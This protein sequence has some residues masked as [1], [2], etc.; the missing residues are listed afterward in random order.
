MSEAGIMR[1]RPFSAVTISI[2]LILALIAGCPAR[3]TPAEFEVVALEIDSDPIAA[4]EPFNVMANVTNKGGTDGVYTASLKVNGLE[5]DS[6][7]I[8]VPA[9]GASDILFP[10]TLEDTGTYTLE[11]G[12]ISTTL[13]VLKPARLIVTQVT[14]SPWFVFPGEEVTITATVRNMGGVTGSMT[15]ILYVNGV[16]EDSRQVTL[17]PDAVEDVSFSLARDVPGEYE[18]DISGSSTSAQSVGVYDAQDYYND[19]Y[20]F[21][22]KYPTDWKVE[23]YLGGVVMQKSDEAVL[24]VAVEVV[25]VEQNPEDLVKSH[26]GILVPQMAWMESDSN[27]EDGTEILKY[28]AIFCITDDSPVP[29]L[30]KD[31]VFIKNGPYFYTLVLEA[32]SSDYWGGNRGLYEECLRSFKPPKTAVDSYTDTAN[33]FSVDLPRGWCAVKPY[34]NYDDRFILDIHSPVDGPNIFMYML[35]DS[36]YED[37]SN[38][39]H[40]ASVVADFSNLPDYKLISEGAVALGTGTEGYEYVFTNTEGRYEVKRRV[41]SIVR[42][43]QALTLV[44]E[45]ADSDYR[46]EESEINQIYDSL[47]FVEKATEH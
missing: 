20:Y 10:V 13:N 45:A 6:K 43:T 42:G 34:E 27:E 40:A 23:E 25:D 1:K 28:R 8:K 47:T 41:V 44:T 21:S 9:G 35:Q 16:E 36:L 19:R 39:E 29:K 30:C 14:V 4:G 38:K 2:L 46:K 22:I 24:I 32:L 11:V 17:E 33:G 15:P 37:T 3:P 18:I 5:V 7:D 26:I 12:G 31:M